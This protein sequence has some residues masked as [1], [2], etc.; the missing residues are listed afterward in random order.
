MRTQNSLLSWGPMKQQFL[1]SG[2][3]STLCDRLV[4]PPQHKEHQGSRDVSF[5]GW[6][7]QVVITVKEMKGLRQ[8]V[9]FTHLRYLLHGGPST[10]MQWSQGAVR[11]CVCSSLCKWE[12]M[13]MCVRV[14]HRSPS[15]GVILHD[16]N[17]FGFWRRGLSLLPRTSDSA[18]LAGKRD[19]GT[20]WFP[21]SQHWDYKHM[22]IM[23]T[24]MRSSGMQI[25]PFLNW[26][27]CPAPNNF[28]NVLLLMTGP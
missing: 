19:L 7:S 4:S 28:D 22:Q 8:T 17:H 2:N 20:Y 18:R 14:C 3:E 26:S 24:E 12:C 25:E 16:S 6:V 13:C 9:N 11:M 5:S 1:C 23:G 27:I 15:H 10:R 21:P